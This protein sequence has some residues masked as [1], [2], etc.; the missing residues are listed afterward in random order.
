MLTPNPTLPTLSTPSGTPTSS[1]ARGS[2]LRI[3]Q[4]APR[5]SPPRS[6][7]QTPPPPRSSC[8]FGRPAAPWVGRTGPLA[9][10]AA[11]QSAPWHPW[12][13]HRRPA[14]G[15]SGAGLRNGEGR[16]RGGERKKSLLISVGGPAHIQWVSIVMTRL[17][18]CAVLHGHQRFSVRLKSLHGAG[19]EAKPR[20]IGF[21][22]S[23]AS[24]NS[25]HLRH[26][27]VCTFVRV[28]TRACMP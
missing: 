15:P 12:P 28:C 23:A 27:G 1:A 18:T 10:A 14:P 16:S 21:V 13:Q 17:H 25:V 24:C 22:A 6:P 9:E 5:P 8:P 20:R 19:F 2:G 26:A 4:A 7:A 11:R 3:S